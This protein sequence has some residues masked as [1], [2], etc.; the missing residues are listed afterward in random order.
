M[1]PLN[2]LDVNHSIAS[3]SSNAFCYERKPKVVLRDREMFMARMLREN[4]IRT[5][6]IAKMMKISERS[7]TRLLAKT[8]DMP[9]IDYGAELIAEVQKL[10]E[11]KDEIL[12]SDMLED[13]DLVQQEVR[14][15]ESKRQLGNSLIAMNVKSK[16]IARMLDVSEKTVQRW[17]G[18]MHKQGSD[19][20]IDEG[21]EGDGKE[22]ISHPVFNDLLDTKEE[23]DEQVVYEEYGDYE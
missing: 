3:T 17:K 11:D 8:K 15:D 5:M 16:D 9:M 21:Q 20:D 1:D 18:K 4:N 14:P 2:V 19:V 12:N 22:E 13:F 23:V 10:M 6:D 7:V